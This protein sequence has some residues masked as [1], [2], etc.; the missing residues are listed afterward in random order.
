VPKSAGTHAWEASTAENLESIGQVPLQPLTVLLVMKARVNMPTNLLGIAAV[1]KHKFYRPSEV[2]IE[3][4]KLDIRLCG[5]FEPSLAV[6]RHIEHPFHSSCFCDCFPTLQ[7]CRKLTRRR[8]I[9]TLGT[10]S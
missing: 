8:Y 6:G 2:V 3:H 5:F 10:S 7:W 1:I 9:C 4:G